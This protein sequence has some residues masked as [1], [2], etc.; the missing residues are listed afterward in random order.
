MHTDSRNSQFSSVQ[1]LTETGAVVGG[2]WRYNSSLPGTNGRSAWFFNGSTHTRIGMFDAAHTGTNGFQYSNSGPIVG[3]RFAA[4]EAWR[5]VGAPGTSPQDMTAWLYDG[6]QTGA[7]GFTGGSFTFASGAQFSDV[8]MLNASGVTAGISA[9]TLPANQIGEVAWVQ[10]HAAAPMRV[11]FYDAAHTNPAGIQSSKPMVLMPDGTVFGQSTL[12]LPN[13]TGGITAWRASTDGQTTAIGLF[14]P[15]YTDPVS[16]FRS[17]TLKFVN[18]SGAIAGITAITLNTSQILGVASWL[19]D[20]PASAPR[21]IGL[22]NAEHTSSQGATSNAISHFNNVGFAGGTAG[23]HV[24]GSGQS[25]WFFDGVTSYHVG[26]TDAEHTR[27]GGEKQS[28]VTQISESGIAAGTSERFLGQFADSGQSAWVFDGTATL[29]VG[30]T[31]A[32]HTSSSGRQDSAPTQVNRTGLVTGTSTQYSTQPGARGTSAWVFDD[33]MTTRL[34]LF[35]ARHTAAN[36]SQD[37]RIA[38]VTDSGLVFGYSEQYY[39]GNIAGGRTLWMYDSVNNGT[40]LLEFHTTPEGRSYSSPTLI[41]DDGTVFGLYERFG[42]APAFGQQP[43]IWRRDLG[44]ADLSSLIDGG[45]DGNGWLELLSITEANSLGQ[46]VG[47]G[48]RANF[49]SEIAFLL[50]PVPEPG[51][52][53]NFIAVLLALR[54]RNRCFNS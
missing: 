40:T 36:G 1:G 2:S 30:L 5:Y 34:G 46:A 17:N 14:G 19:Q 42:V 22:M 51:F 23:R 35:D 41:L 28:R 53:V 25:A 15:D 44:F 33:G 31:D 32:A 27:S 52:L 38:K 54:R 47:Y 21:R 39:L 16:G 18:V 11:G 49:G 26:L 20:N 7:L 13:G 3:Q 8:R 9:F 6:Q 43:F 10:P 45:I 29:R 4:G 50:T 48:R 24:P 12:Y 37:T